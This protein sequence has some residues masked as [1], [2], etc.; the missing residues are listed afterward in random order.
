[1]LERAE[2]IK[3]LV[4]PEETVGGKKL[5]FSDL[6]FLSPE[7]WDDF[8]RDLLELHSEPALDKDLLISSEGIY[9]GL[10]TPRPWY[11]TRYGH[12]TDEVNVLREPTGLPYSSDNAVHLERV[13]D[14]ASQIG[15][16]STKVL[17]TVRRQDTKIASGYAEMSSSIAGASQ[18]HFE[19]WVDKILN[20]PVG[21][22]GLGGAKLNYLTWWKQVSA[23]LGSE[24]VLLLPMELLEANQNE[25]LGRWADFLGLQKSPKAY[26]PSDDA[27]SKKVRVSS[28]S[29]RTWAL[30]PPVSSIRTIP[31]RV[32]RKTGLLSA[33]KRWSSFPTRDEVF[34]LTE[35]TSEKVLA[36]YE[37][38]NRE[39]D[40]R[41]DDINLHQYGYY[42][43]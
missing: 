33:A 4:K 10:G 5:R 31:F 14:V 42:R 3:S 20:D 28:M 36:V 11:K 19:L 43:A 37:D 29:E 22:Y 23:N 38:S 6:F 15:F 30:R 12:M 17:V 34:R 16:D 39:L 7:I 1:M 25:F 13:A 32:L 27:E 9:G 41:I 40:R 8:G 26:L 35:E 24:N 18:K 2:G 21:Y